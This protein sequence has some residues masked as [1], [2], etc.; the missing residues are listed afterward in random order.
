TVATTAAPTTAATTTVAPTTEAPTTT[1]APVDL[2]AL[3]TELKTHYADT[4]ENE[5][6][7]AEADLTLLE[8]IGDVAITWVSANATYLEN[9]GTIHRPSFDLGDQTVILSATM[10]DGEE[11]ESYNFFVTV[12]ALD[13]SDQERANEVF[14]VATAFPSKELWTSA[15]NDE[16]DFVVTGKDADDVDYTIVWTSSH[17]DVISVDGE[18]TQPLDADVDVTMTATITIDSVDYTED[19]VFS[20]AKMLE[21]TEVATIAAAIA[22]GEE[23]YVKIMGVTVIAVNEMGDVYFTDGTDI[24]YIYSASFDPIVGNVY[25]I[26][27]EVDFYY[28][29]PQLKGS[30]VHPLRAED[31]MALV[32]A[33]PITAAVAITD[34]ISGLTTPTPENMFA[35]EI[36]EVTAKVYYEEDWGNYSVFLVPTDYDFG[37]ALSSSTQPNGDSIMIYYKSNM[38]T[39]AP[40]HDGKEITIQI[41]TQGWRSDK[42]VWYGNF[43][44]EVTDIQMT[45]ADDAEAVSTALAAFDLPEEVKEATTLD[46]MSELY[47]VTLTY[48]SDDE[49]VINSTT[50]VVDL[51]GL[52]SRQLVTI[53]VTATKGTDTDTKV[54]EIQVGELP[55]LTIAEALALADDDSVKIQGIV[56]GS[57]YYNTFLIQDATGGIAVYTYDSDTKDFLE[58]NIGNLV[59]IIG[60]RASYKGLLQIKPETATFVE[61]SVLPTPMNLDAVAEAD[62]YDYHGMLVEFTDLYVDDVYADS[63]GNVTVTFI[64]LS[65]STEIEMKWDSRVSLSAAAE[66]A[67]NSIAVG[68]KVSVIAGL[69]WYND[70]RLFYADDTTIIEGTPYTDAEL[71]AVDAAMFPAELTLSADYDLPEL[72]F[73]TATVA[74]SAELQANLTDDILTNS[75]IDVLVPG[76]DDLTGIVTFTLTLNAETTNVVIN[77]VIEAFTEADKLAADLVELIAGAA[78]VEAMEYQTFELPIMGTYG[79]VITWT[80][81]SGTATIN[82]NEIYLDPTGVSHDVVVEATLT[83]GSE[84]PV[85]QQFTLTVAPVTLV[86]DFATLHDN[87]AG[88]FT[89]ADDT[90]VYVSGVVIGFGYHVVYIQDA[91]GEGLYAYYGEGHEND[92]TI[93]I[94]DEVIYYGLLDSYN[95]IRRLGDG[96]ELHAVISMSN[97]IID[98]DYT[99]DEV[100]A[101]AIEDTGKIISVTGLVYTG[102]NYGKLQF[103]VIGTSTMTLELYPTSAPDWFLDVFA[104]SDVLPEVTFMYKET[105]YGNL[106]VEIFEIVMTDQMMLDADV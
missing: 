72:L 31:S 67:V 30:D 27:G 71:L 65:D 52:V 102:M 22:L 87:T 63:Y 50:G 19:V 78:E 56:I 100:N 73:S 43:F 45:F 75:Q 11:T 77:V 83:L 9:D 51:T 96:A 25:D 32:S 26:T 18:I 1:A 84:T 7:L 5:S 14:L 91:N 93:N 15:D 55:L 2:P 35:Y 40:F 12:K 28:N 94:G 103:D 36:Y 16:L 92:G 4:L 47:G 66:L 24:L 57:E 41:I 13:K 101:L 21:G 8:T 81:V 97:A 88:V 70:A 80:L 10:V 104:V 64:R 54:I 85:V 49:A 90:E 48:T 60:A 17:P 39:L 61:E 6:Y 42:M 46:L 23:A 20:V 86:T 82:V 38:E 76:V 89:I 74:I 59:E 29:A 3:M 99:L 34:I 79:S 106:F 69:G 44:G 98:F 37:A 62:L 105:A 53:T 58:A 68:D 95:G 33:A